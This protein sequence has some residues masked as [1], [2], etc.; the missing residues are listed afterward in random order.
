MGLNSLGDSQLLMHGGNMSDVQSA[1][2]ECTPAQDL[3]RAGNAMFAQA[4]YY[5]AIKLYFQVI[6]PQRY[7]DFQTHGFSGIANM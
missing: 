2:D 7:K 1:N 6:T 3:L 4:K 5:D